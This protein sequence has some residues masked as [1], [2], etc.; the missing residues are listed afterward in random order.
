MHARKT[1]K[2]TQTSKQPVR[3]VKKLT[4][5]FHYPS[6][7]IFLCKG[8]ELKRSQNILVRHSFVAAEILKHKKFHETKVIKLVG[9]LCG[10]VKIAPSQ[11]VQPVFY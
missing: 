5:F 10:I 11:W 3:S 2:T 9:D 6:N 7:E 8:V 1:S 4:K